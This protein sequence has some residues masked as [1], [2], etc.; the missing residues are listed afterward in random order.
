MTCHKLKTIQPYYGL[1]VHGYKLF[2]IRLNDRDFQVGDE[3]L[4]EL[5]D[6]IKKAYMGS[7]KLF[8]ITCIVSAIGLKKG[9]VVFGLEVK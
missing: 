5:W 2:E 4:L 7:S 6:P 8:E 1:T 9:Y 3:A